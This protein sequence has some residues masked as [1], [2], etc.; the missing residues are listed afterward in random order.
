MIY[1][2]NAAT[3]R[4]SLAVLECFE[5]ENEQCFANPSSRHAYGREAYRKLENARFS[6]LKSLS[7]SNDYRVLFTSGASESN[8]LAIKGIA[9][10]YLRRGKR[11]ITTQVEHPSV[12]E[13]FR[14]LEKEG[15]EV[16]YLPTKEDGTVDPETLKENMNKETILVSIM[17]TNNETGSNNDILALSKIVHSFPKAFFHVDVTQAIGKRD[18]PYSSIDLFSFSG[19]KIHGLKGTGALILKKNITLLRQIDGG[20]QEYFFR[21]GTDNLPGDETLAVAL[22]EA[23]KNLQDNIAHAKE[24]SSFLREELEKNDEILMNSP[25]EGSPFILN[26][27]LKRKKAS[28]VTEALSHEGIYVSSVS[29]C[30]S[31]GEPISYV[32]EA[33]GFS[34]ER[35][36]NSIRLSF[37]RENTL[38]EAKTF[39]NTLQNILERTINR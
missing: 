13:T 7:L 38:E 9:K 26:F 24:I 33:M 32:L 31:K 11:I 25:L 4:P 6:I 29:A 18:L 35:A 17:A 5:K 36:M 3:T 16:I 23:T 8:N 34:K 2:D 21:A 19:H 15:F 22:E 39:L 12:L 37:S 27:S 1:F 20:D 28:V 10:E 30:N 14:S